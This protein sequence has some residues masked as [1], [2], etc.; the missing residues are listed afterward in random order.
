MLAK[1]L[2]C[3]H[4]FDVRTEYAG[5]TVMCPHCKQETMVLTDDE[6]R[7]FAQSKMISKRDRLNRSFGSATEENPA[8]IRLSFWLGFLLNA[9]GIVIAAAIGGSACVKSALKGFLINTLGGIF[10]GAILMAL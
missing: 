8:D 4:S 3:N 6:R 1:C 9:L 7:R 5:C 10:I 2:K